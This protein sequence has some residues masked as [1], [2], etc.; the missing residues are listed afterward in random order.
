[1]STL[2]LLSAPTFSDDA[3]KDFTHSFDY[4]GGASS[5][6]IISAPGWTGD[7]TSVMFRVSF[8]LDQVMSEDRALYLTS[9]IVVGS[10]PPV[11]VRVKLR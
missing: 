6:Y 5:S 4:G 7:T 1:M 2:P 8:P 3:G 10:L 11:P 9:R